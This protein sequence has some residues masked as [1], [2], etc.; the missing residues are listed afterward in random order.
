MPMPCWLKHLCSIRAFFLSFFLFLSFS[1]S[2]YF[3]LIPWNAEAGCVTKGILA[4]FLLPLSYCQ[5]R[6]TRFQSIKGPTISNVIILIIGRLQ[7]MGWQRVGHHWMTEHTCT[8]IVLLLLFK[9][10]DS[11]VWLSNLSSKRV[12]FSGAPSM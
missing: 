2:L 10:W 1:L 7:S 11:S 4:S 12:F 9:I 6:A 5:L 3:W 8:H